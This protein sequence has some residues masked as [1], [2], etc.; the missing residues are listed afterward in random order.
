MP[1]CPI[2]TCRSV[3]VSACR[4]LVFLTVCMLFLGV[5]FPSLDT[6]SYFVLK[7]RQHTTK[8]RI[9]LPRQH[10]TKCLGLHLFSFQNCS[11]SP[12]LFMMCVLSVFLSDPALCG[13]P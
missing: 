8:C 7:A 12:S 11:P 6:E 1:V 10:I 13:L 3:C 5:R 2:V 4:G 9:V